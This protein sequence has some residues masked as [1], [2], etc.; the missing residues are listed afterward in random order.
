MVALVEEGLGHVSLLVWMNQAV[1]WRI[2][3]SSE[4][5]RS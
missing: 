4:W 3:A 5:P 1:G 2:A